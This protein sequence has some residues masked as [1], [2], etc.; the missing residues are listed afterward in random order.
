M[1][2]KKRCFVIMPFS[3][4]G[5]YEEGH[6]RNVYEDVIQPAVTRAGYECSRCDDNRSS[7][8]IQLEILQELLTADVVVC[9][10]S[11]HNPNVM[12]EL[13]LRQAF[14]KPV[15]LIRDDKTDDIFDIAGFRYVK[16]PKDLTYKDVIIAQKDISESITQ[17][18]GNWENDNKVNSLVRLM[19]I[20]KASMPKPADE[21]TQIGI[22]LDLLMSE[23]SSLKRTVSDRKYDSGSSPAQKLTSYIQDLKSMEKIVSDSPQSV[24][25]YCDKVT[26]ELFKDNYI[27][28]FDSP[29]YDLYSEVSKRI[30]DL[31]QIAYKACQNQSETV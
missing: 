9:D 21:P 16:Y 30:S 26:H 24:I 18:V 10:L 23:I 17:T 7:N 15:V 31:R 6:F 2:D 11:S 28:N 27:Q 4:R 19:S 3:E 20:S 13:G 5:N 29:Y 22:K 14:D 12:F 1:S 25:R 8:L